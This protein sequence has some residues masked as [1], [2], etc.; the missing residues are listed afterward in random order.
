[1]IS[2]LSTP[3]FDQCV[4][5][6]SLINLCN[7]ES[8][9]GQTI[10]QLHNRWQEDELT[11]DPWRNLHQ[12]TLH[13][14]HPEQQYEGITLEAGL[15]KGYN[16]EAKTVVDRTRLPYKIPEGGQFV[17]VMKQKGLDG[18]FEI[19]A[20]GIFVRPL[21][22]LSLDWI[23]DRITPEYQSMIVKHPVIRDYP[24]SWEEQLKRFLKQEI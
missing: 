24:S 8:Y 4:L 21:A 1:M 9:A 18:D 20:T 17:V 15:S 13:I 16:I 2:I 7:Q 23:V 3:Q 5:N 10:R 14:P 22:V 6:I 12:L 19:A 11:H